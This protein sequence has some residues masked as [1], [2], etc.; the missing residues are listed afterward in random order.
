MEGTQI[1][2][3]DLVDSGNNTPQWAI[4]NDVVIGQSGTIATTATCTENG[5]IQ[6]SIGDINRIVK[7]RGGWQAVTNPSVPTLGTNRQSDT[8]L[9]IE[10]AASV[11]RPGSNQGVNTIGEIFSVT[12]VRR[13]AE[14]E[15]PTGSSDVSDENPYGLPPNSETYIVDGGDDYDVAY[16]IYIKKN[17]GCALNQEGVPV[18][19]TVTDKVYHRNTKLIK[20]GR[21]TPVDMVMVIELKNDG[22]LPSD[23]EQQVKAA[24]I[25][26]TNGELLPVDV[27]FNIQGFYIGEDVPISRM[28]TPINQ[29]IG[30]YGNSYINSLT[31]NTLTS[32]VVTIEFDELARFSES[33][34]TV[35]IV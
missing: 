13:V 22:S 31:I 6:A 21:P 32:G 26:Y 7:A 5:A 10:R 11:A 29:V 30:S 25:E 8:S 23:V 9:R 4:D 34:I 3:G 28:N 24:I 17:Q 33:N 27:G 35:T 1:F 14:Y 20:Y 19:V 18:S 2:K 16:A 12:G 15:N